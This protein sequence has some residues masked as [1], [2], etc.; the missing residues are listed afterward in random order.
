M[1][2]IGS[3]PKLLSSLAMPCVSRWY[4]S[5]D[6][7]SLK[8]R[9]GWFTCEATKPRFLLSTCGSDGRMNWAPYA[10]YTRYLPASATSLFP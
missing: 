1:K 3:E 2:V 5:S 6:G 9:C 8:V 4:I 10:F 7:L